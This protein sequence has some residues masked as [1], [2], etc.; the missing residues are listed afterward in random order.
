LG[1]ARR[2]VRSGTTGERGFRVSELNGD[3][4]AHSLNDRI[5]GSRHSDCA[6]WFELRTIGPVLLIC[7]IAIAA[8]ALNATP[9]TYAIDPARSSATIAVGKSGIFSFA[10]GHTHEVIAPSITGHIT[11]DPA[12][13]SRSMVRVTIDASALKVTGKGEPP[14]DVPRV[15][16]TMASEQVLD[17]RRYPTIDFDSTS[18]SVKSPG[19]TKL[20]VIVNGRLTLHN[21]TRSV[22]VPVMVQI[23]PHELSATG[24]FSL[25]Q[26]DYGIK[27][28]SVGGVVSVKD[29]VNINFMIVGRLGGQ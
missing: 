24:S 4:R 13:P 26:T 18:I 8:V 5:D 21:V 28:V 6:G 2:T 22:S 19:T 17:V 29:T 14:D 15:Q 7:G 3:S 11:V 25:K 1:R 16:Q 20:D 10:A 9:Q 27:P 23:D 12:D